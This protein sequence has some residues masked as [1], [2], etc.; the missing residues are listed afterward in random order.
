MK[1]FEN[2]VTI[3]FLTKKKVND[4]VGGIIGE[5]FLYFGAC[6]YA[7]NADFR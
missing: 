6:S 7:Q 4:I 5:K 3:F 1:K 2:Q